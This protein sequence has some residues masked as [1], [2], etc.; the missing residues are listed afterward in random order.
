MKGTG[1]IIVVQKAGTKGTT[2]YYIHVRVQ[3]ALAPE[4]MDENAEQKTTRLFLMK[5]TAREARPLPR[6]K[7]EGK[8]CR[9]SKELSRSILPFFLGLLGLVLLRFIG[10]NGGGIG[11]SGPDLRFFRVVEDFL[12]RHVVGHLKNLPLFL[13]AELFQLSFGKVLRDSLIPFKIQGIVCHQRKHQPLVEDPISPKHA[14][15]LNGS[16][17]TKDLFKIFNVL[18]HK[19]HPPGPVP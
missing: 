16:E 6:K 13:V 18:A 8:S 10:A 15:R 4:P 17:F 19:D 12:R 2:G 5:L 11:S 7:R 9:A 1:K 14:A 3:E